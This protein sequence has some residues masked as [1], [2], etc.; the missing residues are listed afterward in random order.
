M[1]G[2]W[3]VSKKREGQTDAHKNKGSLSLGI[4]CPVPPQGTP[5][6]CASRRNRLC[7]WNWPASDTALV[8]VTLMQAST[9]ISINRWWILDQGLWEEHWAFITGTGDFLQTSID[10]SRQWGNPAEL[11]PSGAD[12]PSI[13]PVIGQ[14][15]LA[16]PYSPVRKQMWH[17]PSW[18]T[19]GREPAVGLAVS[20]PT[21]CCP[22]DWVVTLS[23]CSL[24]QQKSIFWFKWEK[25]N[26]LPSG[27]SGGGHPWA[28]IPGSVF[29][30]FVYHTPQ[31]AV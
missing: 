19:A 29:C 5:R 2:S 1:I 21:R 13:P 25:K 23:S 31:L 18:A 8:Y 14:F 22:R 28:S 27:Q 24:T 17:N 11:E 16:L 4:R 30:L 9:N 3:R 12:S 15:S 6:P 26:E 20:F 10:F 7:T